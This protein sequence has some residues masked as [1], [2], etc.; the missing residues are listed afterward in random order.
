MPPVRRLQLKPPKKLPRRSLTTVTVMVELL[1][2][3]ALLTTDGL[4]IMTMTTVTVMVIDLS[5]CFVLESRNYSSSSSIFTRHG[6][7]NETS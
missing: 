4:T 5:V 1:H 3:P 6:L 2:V 7:V